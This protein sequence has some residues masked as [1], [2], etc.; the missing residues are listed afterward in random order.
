[1]RQQLIETQ[2][3]KIVDNSGNPRIEMGVDEN[4]NPL[5]R[6]LQS[7]GDPCLSIMLDPVNQNPS[8]LMWNPKSN[9]SISLMLREDESTISLSSHSSNI[10]IYIQS[11]VTGSQILIS[12][13]HVPRISLGEQSPSTYGIA[14][15]DDKD[16]ILHLV[17]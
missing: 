9:G 5:F 15:T 7:N 17:P 11:K 12:H 1:V 13:D 14:I 8:I 3:L 4:Q 2:A 16:Q 10:G 6:F